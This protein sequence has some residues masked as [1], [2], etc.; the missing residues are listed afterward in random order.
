MKRLLHTL[1]ICTLPGTVVL[2][3]Q[4]ITTSGGTVTTGEGSMSFVIGQMTY[5]NSSEIAFGVLQVFD[6]SEP[7]LGAKNAPLNMSIFP[8]P[9]QQ[10]IRINTTAAQLD[11]SYQLVDA[12]GKELRSDLITDENLTIDVSDLSPN[13]YYLKVSDRFSIIRSFKILK[14]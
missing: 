12:Q 9:A 6:E 13:I 7:A 4:S 3:Q 2:S 8:N 1:I 5:I 11:L 14:Q 10:T